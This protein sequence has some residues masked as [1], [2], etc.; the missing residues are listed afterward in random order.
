MDRGEVPAGPG[1]GRNQELLTGHAVAG[2]RAGGHHRAADGDDSVDDLEDPALLLPRAGGGIDTVKLPS[3]AR[4]PD[5]LRHTGKVLIA[6][7][8][9][10]EYGFTDVDGKTP[11][12][13]TLADV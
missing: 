9:A 2:L 3:L 13:L 11:R 8:L 4:D 5:V 10:A 6:A 12:A 7:A 1:I